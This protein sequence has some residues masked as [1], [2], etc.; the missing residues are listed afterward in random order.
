MKQDNTITHIEIPSP[1]LAKAVS[2]YSKVFNWKIEIVTENSYAF[3]RIGDTNTGGGLDASLKPGEEKCGHQI[4]V[5]V[6]NIQ[7]TLSEVKTAGGSVTIVKTE[8]GGGHGFYACFKDPNGNH[9]Q[10]HANI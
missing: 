7:Q 6:E 8:I 3:F 2:F 4:C 5:D 1:D 9:L 10:I